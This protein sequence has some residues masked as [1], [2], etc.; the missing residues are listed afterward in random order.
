VGKSLFQEASF[1]V[2]LPRLLCHTLQSIGVFV[3]RDALQASWFSLLLV[4]V[5][6][7]K[8]W[9]WLRG[10]ITELSA[11]QSERKK[12]PELCL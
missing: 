7:G 4:M 9:S 12:Q 3:R 11:H 2:S 6:A 10:A 8:H 1:S 5:L